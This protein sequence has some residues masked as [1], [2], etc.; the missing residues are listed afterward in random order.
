VSVLKAHKVLLV[1]A[2]CL[3]IVQQDDDGSS[4]RAKTEVLRFTCRGVARL[5]RRLKV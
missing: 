3:G 1:E 4:I 2:T 5:E